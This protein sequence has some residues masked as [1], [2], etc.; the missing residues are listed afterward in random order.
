MNEAINQ[1][2]LAGE[3]FMSEM[4]LP[5]FTYSGCRPFTKINNKIQKFKESGDSS[6]IYQNHLDKAYFQQDM[7]Y[8]ES[9]T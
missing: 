8:G 9:I 6:C 7:A 2:L 5:G 3:T 4:R 1:F